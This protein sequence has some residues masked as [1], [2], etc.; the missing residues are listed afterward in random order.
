[1]KE[2]TDNQQTWAKRKKATG[3]NPLVELIMLLGGGILG[4][5]NSP[6]AGPDAKTGDLYRGR[7]KTLRDAEYK[8]GILGD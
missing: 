5:V 8:S 4:G 6:M 3:M 7:G 1:M 2:V